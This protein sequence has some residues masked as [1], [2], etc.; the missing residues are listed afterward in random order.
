MFLQKC[1]ISDLRVPLASTVGPQKG[2]I[3]TIVA[4]IDIFFYQTKIRCVKKGLLQNM[5]SNYTT[6]MTLE[7]IKIQ[8]TLVIGAQGGG[9]LSPFVLTA[10]R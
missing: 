10:I 5:I 2:E 1:A 3:V 9:K 8:N 6:H 4:K 7:Y